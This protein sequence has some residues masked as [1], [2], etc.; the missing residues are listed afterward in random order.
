M[1]RFYDWFARNRARIG[2]GFLVAIGVAQADPLV[3]DHP[4]ASLGLA[5][6][7]AYIRAAGAHKSDE[8]QRDKQDEAKDERSGGDPC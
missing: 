5:M 2:F 1:G 3:R 6:V 7:A 8:Y 4:R